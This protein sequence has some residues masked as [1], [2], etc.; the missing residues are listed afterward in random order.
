MLIEMGMKRR[1]L[2]AAF[3]MVA[4]SIPL[5][6]EEAKEELPF[7]FQ[8]R[9]G[10]LPVAPVP[11]AVPE[12][13]F[14]D[15][16]AFERWLIGT[17]WQS[18]DGKHNLKLVFK[19]GGKAEF[20]WSNPAYW[21]ITGAN[22]CKLRHSS[23]HWNCDLVISDSML[24]LKYTNGWRSNGSRFSWGEAKFVGRKEAEKK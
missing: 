13:G 23:S 2:A 21:K 22:R 9:A 1:I 3:L 17:T 16:K 14:K 11:G 24:T 19:S 6:A 4:L 12:G 7:Y 15:V 8:D 20:T 10:K 18:S 5:M